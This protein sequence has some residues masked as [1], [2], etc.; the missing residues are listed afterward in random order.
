[1]LTRGVKSRMLSKVLTLK[2]FGLSLGA[3]ALMGTGTAIAAPLFP[4]T[5]QSSQTAQQRPAEGPN[6]TSDDVIVDTEPQRP[7]STSNGSSSRLAGTRFSCQQSG[8]QFVVMYHPES[9]P[10]QSYPW[11]NPTAMGGGWTPELRCREISRRLESYRPDGLLEMRT[12]IENGYNIVCV[13]TQKVPGCRIVLT[14]PPGQ[15]PIVTRDRVFQN[16]TV[17]DSGQQTQAVNTFVEGNRGSGIVDELG[18]LINV[19]LPELGQRSSYSD[20]IDLRP[21]LDRADGGTGAYLQRGVS[22]GPT[23]R[24]NPDR[25][26]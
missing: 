16:L 21:F 24:L 12:A 8:G 11:A 25:F 9:Q 5:S 4:N 22:N 18:R 26:R 19:N 10:G 23:P 6:T 3:V 1:M 7:N 20:A 14:V 13:T 15:D 2:G 17:A